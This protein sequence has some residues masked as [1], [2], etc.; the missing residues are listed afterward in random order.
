M[1]RLFCSCIAAASLL[2][3]TAYADDIAEPQ[4]IN[5]DMESTEEEPED[6]AQE[7][8]SDSEDITVSVYESGWTTGLG[9]NLGLGPAIDLLDPCSGYSARIGLDIHA[10]YWGIGLE[11]TWNTVW[12]TASASRPFHRHDFAD[13]TSNSG[14]ML[15]VKGFLPTSDSFVMS[16]GA[17]IGLG[18][19]YEDFSDN[20]EDVHTSSMMDASW[21]A[22]FQTGAMWLVA[23]CLTLGFDLEL[24]L[25]NYWS[26][27]PRWNSDDK[28]DISLGAILTFS[29]QLFLH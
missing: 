5:L 20:P 21:L 25:G 16:L 22:R 8:I 9:I 19:R 18:A 17:G 14:L 1:K 23:D 13:E 29:Y 26:K 11:V 4:R 3:A 6:V 15:L 2:S 24:N 7:D 10:K 12:S 28:L 27:L